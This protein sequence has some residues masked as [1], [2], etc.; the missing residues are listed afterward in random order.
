MA[1][2]QGIAW[3]LRAAALGAALWGAARAEDAAA[4]GAGIQALIAQ[5]GAA[6][7]ETREAAQE[8]LRAF[9][10]AARG[11]L[12]AVLD[13]DDLETA[14]GAA[15][16]LRSINR[17]VIAVRVTDDEGRPRAN[18]EVSLR[19]FRGLPP[20]CRFRLGWKTERARSDG[21]G[22]ATFRDYEPGEGYRLALDC[23]PE[24]LFGQSASHPDQVLKV[25]R[26]EYVMKCSTQGAKV[27]GVLLD[28][29]GKPLA[30]VTVR[31]APVGW[32][33]GG[34]IPGCGAMQRHPSFTSDARGAFLFEGLKSQEYVVVVV[35]GLEVLY[36]SQSLTS[37]GQGTVDLG[38]IA[39]GLD[40]QELKVGC[41]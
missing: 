7:Y 6:K 20:S 33:G 21:E 4:D 10:E 30:G 11:A 13:R 31:L 40:A 34:R 18:A 16:V 19:V 22:W 29:E 36:K 9:G 32:V 24:G 15:Y 23:Q 27:K 26:N 35:R 17:A 1:T 14:A 39:T 3:A 37:G 28:K 41:P 38:E 25:G 5:L 8:D 12:E 2:G